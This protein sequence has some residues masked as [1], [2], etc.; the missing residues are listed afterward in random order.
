M[1]CSLLYICNLSKREYPS[2]WEWQ[3]YGVNMPCWISNC[4]RKAD[5]GKREYTGTQHPLLTEEERKKKRDAYT[6]KRKKNQTRR[7]M[8]RRARELKEERRAREKAL[9]ESRRTRYSDT[10]EEDS[11]TEEE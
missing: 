3:P 4:V 6:R 10:E 9:V 8:R 5:G 7:K 2:R 1:K 11:D